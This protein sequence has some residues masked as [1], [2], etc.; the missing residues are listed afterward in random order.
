M[1]GEEEEWREE[2]NDWKRWVGIGVDGSREGEGHD[3]RGEL[4]E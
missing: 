3:M 4:G 1:E 2:L